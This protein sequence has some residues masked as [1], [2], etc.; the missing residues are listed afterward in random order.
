MTGGV[1]STWLSDRLAVN[2]TVRVFVQRNPDFRLPEVTSTPKIMIGPGTG[3]APF[4]SFLKHDKVS[5]F[6]IK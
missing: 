2:D 6:F 4:M 5:F 1:A 3:V